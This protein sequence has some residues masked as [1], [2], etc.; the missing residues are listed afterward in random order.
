VGKRAF[1]CAIHYASRAFAHAAYGH[2]AL[3]VQARNGFS[4]NRLDMKIVA[5]AN[6]AC[7]NANGGQRRSSKF[8]TM[9]RRDR[10]LTPTRSLRAGLHVR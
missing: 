10:L 3:I 1:D 9:R 7:R 5:S 6:S 2:N 8:A 4:T